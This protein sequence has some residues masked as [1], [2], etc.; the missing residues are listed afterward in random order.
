MSDKTAPKRKRAKA[1][2]KQSDDTKDKVP[3]VCE[4][5]I[6]AV[7]VKHG[8]VSFSLE[9][10]APYLFEKKGDDGKPKRLLLFVDDP[11]KPDSARIVGDNEEALFS[12]PS[13]KCDFSAMLIAKANR[14]KVRVKLEF[15]SPTMSVEV[16]TVL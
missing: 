6:K 4:G 15:Q 8:K 7:E 16:L 12:V 10:S 2:P 9:P 1:G 3:Y 5:F 11:Q 13:K 14:L